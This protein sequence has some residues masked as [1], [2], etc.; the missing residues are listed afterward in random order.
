MVS[1]E[2]SFLVKQNLP[3][4]KSIS[5]KSL[6]FRFY[7]RLFYSKLQM[8]FESMEQVFSLRLLSFSIQLPHLT[9]TT[10]KETIYNRIMWV[11][12]HTARSKR[13]SLRSINFSIL[14]SWSASFHVTMPKS[15]R[16][17]CCLKIVFILKSI[18]ILI[19]LW[20][21]NVF[22]FYFCKT[23]SASVSIR[24]RSGAK[25]MRKS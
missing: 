24:W 23:F 16:R 20:N 8:H 3:K 9:M 4:Q 13:I 10:E 6:L 7:S 22:Y 21:R 18:E 5:M 19:K 15:R 12:N 1:L 14:S 2:E 11:I 25:L 17:F